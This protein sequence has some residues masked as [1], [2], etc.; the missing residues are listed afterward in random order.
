MEKRYQRFTRNGKEW[1]R[2][3]STTETPSRWQLKPKLL[4]QYREEEGAQPFTPSEETTPEPQH[5]KGH[6]ANE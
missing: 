2:W 6:Y 1:S 4:N 3:F 5:A